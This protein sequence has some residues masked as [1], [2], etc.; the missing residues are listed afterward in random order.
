MHSFW[1]LLCM[2]R[3]LNDPQNVPSC[4]L[5]R[6]TDILLSYTWAKYYITQRGEAQ[7]DILPLIFFLLLKSLCKLWQASGYEQNIWSYNSFVRSS[8]PTYIYVHNMLK[9]VISTENFDTSCFLG[10]SDSYKHSP[11]RWP[12]LTVLRQKESSSFMLSV[13]Y[14]SFR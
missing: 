1:R 10:A 13:L 12:P 11:G 2:S 6:F 3:H 9:G 5:V 7:C 4:S 8:F 14:S